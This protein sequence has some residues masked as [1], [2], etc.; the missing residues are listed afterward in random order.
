MPPPLYAPGQSWH[1][2]APPAQQQ[3]VA[4]ATSKNAPPGLNSL[5]QDRPPSRGADRHRGFSLQ[6]EEHSVSPPKVARPSW[7]AESQAYPD[8]VSPKRRPLV[9][10]IQQDFPRTP[11][12]VLFQQQQAQQQQVQQPPFGLSDPLRAEWNALK[13]GNRSKEQE[14]DDFGSH[15]TASVL[16]AALDLE[17]KDVPPRAYSTP[18][19][20]SVQPGFQ[21]R[22]RNG[23]PQDDMAPELAYAM[24][25]MGLND[26]A[27]YRRPHR[28][29]DDPLAPLPNQNGYASMQ[30]DYGQYANGSNGRGYTN[31]MSSKG[32]FTDFLNAHKLEMDMYA[33]YEFQQLGQVRDRSLLTDPIFDRP[34]S[35]QARLGYT[36]SADRSPRYG[37]YDPQAYDSR[38]YR[39]SPPDKKRMGGVRRE[40]MA[41]ARG[42]SPGPESG[43]LRSELLEEFRNNKNKKYELRV[44]LFQNSQGSHV[45]YSWK[46]C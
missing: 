31:R 13:P 5:L 28:D 46:C 7:P 22:A 43:L 1:L 24:R 41:P 16:T 9:D 36:P 44:C 33:A 29:Y 34:M 25:N 18:P 26:D 19:V 37:Q 3:A 2:W 15:M 21:S 20:R 11:S 23:M 35:A 45:G 4:N 27:D 40:N 32:D 39:G 38:G 12:P 42:P 8:Y 6:D 17:L 14:D 10:L 30:G